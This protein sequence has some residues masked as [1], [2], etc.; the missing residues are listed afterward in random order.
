MQQCC[1][2]KEEPTKEGFFKLVLSYLQAEFLRG[3]E[4]DEEGE[5]ERG[6]LAAGGGCA[7]LGCQSSSFGTRSRV[8]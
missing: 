4:R 5:V 1:L 6:P 7:G 2:R 8:R 3:G